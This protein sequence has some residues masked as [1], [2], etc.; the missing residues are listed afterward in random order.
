MFK[1]ILII[2]LIITLVTL[3]G[4]GIYFYLYPNELTRLTTKLNNLQRRPKPMTKQEQIDN[5]KPVDIDLTFVPKTSVTKEERTLINKID[6][7]LEEQGFAININI[8]KESLRKLRIEQRLDIIPIFGPRSIKR[9]EDAG[10]V[11]NEKILNDI[12]EL[13]IIQSKRR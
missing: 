8:D 3:V 10:F 12:N 2:I 11:L 4:F 13:S 5:L 7:Q 9:L 1:E 6:N